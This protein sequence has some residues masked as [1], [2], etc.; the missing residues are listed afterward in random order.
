MRSPITAG[1]GGFLME[2]CPSREQLELLTTKKLAPA[3]QAAV[4][5]HVE[6][7]TPCQQTLAALNPCR[8]TEDWQPP[9]KA[10][11]EAPGDAQVPEELRQHPR[12]RVL[13]VLGRG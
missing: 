7:C 12:Y 10:E 8:P 13:G 5:T 9:A 3:S 11:L 4:A 1:A 2:P 6:G